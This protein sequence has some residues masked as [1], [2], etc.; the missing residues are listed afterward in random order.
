MSAARTLVASSARPEARYSLA[1]LGVIPLEAAQPCSLSRWSPTKEMARVLAPNVARKLGLRRSEVV[2]LVE[3]ILD[4][5]RV[6]RPRVVAM[7]LAHGHR[8][9]HERRRAADTDDQARV[10][11]LRRHRACELLGREDHLEFL[12][13]RAVGG[14]RGHDDDGDE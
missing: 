9:R 8:A 5:R 13:G 3:I 6:R 4:H 11:A 2:P 10:R 1:S 14:G 12:V 7:N